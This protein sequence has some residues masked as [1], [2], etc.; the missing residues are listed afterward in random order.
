[1]LQ[2]GVGD[3]CHERVDEDLAR[4][5]LQSDQARVSPSAADGPVRKSIVP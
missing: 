4:I 2:E 1:M 5:A 3:H